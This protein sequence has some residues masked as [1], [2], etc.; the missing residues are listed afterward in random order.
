MVFAT[1]LPTH[2]DG[3]RIAPLF[4]TLPGFAHG[5][6][7]AAALTLQDTKFFSLE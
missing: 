6:K 5:Y 2:T 3:L 1:G 4:N 7:Y